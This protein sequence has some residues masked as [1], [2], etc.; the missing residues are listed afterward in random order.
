MKDTGLNYSIVSTDNIKCFEQ[1]DS[2]NV[3][4]YGFTIFSFLSIIVTTLTSCFIIYYERHGS[5]KKRTLIN[6]L[7]SSIYWNGIL[8]NFTIQS[9]YTV[10]FAFGPLPG[11]TCFLLFILRKT[12]VINVALLLNAIT[13]T[14]YIF[15]FWL[16]NPAAFNDDFWCVL[17]NIWTF[18]FSFVFQFLRALVPGNQLLEYNI[19]AGNDPTAILLLP[20]F[21]RGYIE[22]FGIILHA[23]VYIR[24]TVYKKKQANTFGP[25]VRS[26][27]LKNLILSDVDERSISS[28]ATNVCCIIVIASG[29]ILAEVGN[30]KSCFDLNTFPKYL[31]V[32]YSYLFIPGFL[33]MLIFLVYHLKNNDL[34]RTTFRQF[35]ECCEVFMARMSQRLI[36]LG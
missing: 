5:D 22:I 21:A 35:A 8:W 11:F 12:I 28:F 13:F 17:I 27:F 14:R 6:K 32:Y 36:I 2:H 30:L 18:S 4:K 24:I 7:L 20:S 33:N 3:Y 1:L 15:I 10:R 23:F 29:F 34:K 16:K 19:C 9:L 26:K 31:S 25:E